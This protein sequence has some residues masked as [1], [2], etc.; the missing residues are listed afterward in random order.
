MY[1]FYGWEQATVPAITTEYEGIKTPC[2]MY[3]VMLSV[4]SRETCAPRYRGDW[5]VE[6]KTCGQCSISSF[7]IQDIFGGKVYGVPLEGGGVHC[8]NVVDGHKFD[9]TSEQFGDQK[10]NYD[11]CPEQFREDHFADEEKFKRYEMLEKGLKA[12]TLFKQGYNCSQAV[13]M[14]FAKDLDIDESL[15]A[16]LSVG[17]GGGVGRSRE[18][19]GTVTGMAIVLGIKYGTYNPLSKNDVYPV[20]QQAIEDFKKEMGS[21]VCHELLE[22]VKV[23]SGATAETRTEEFYKKR[24]CAE[25]VGL[26][27][28]IAEKL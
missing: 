22:G 11:D 6:N 27:A 18:V 12:V 20:V 5:S 21:I 1:K 4:W 8:F 24:P 3:D 2:D 10:L 17:L 16:K 13:A 25:L 19:C 26:A 23:T 28:E 7:L 9:L 14:A 15:M